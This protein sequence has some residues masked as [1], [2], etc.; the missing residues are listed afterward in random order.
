MSNLAY[1]SILAVIPIGLGIWYARQSE[2][3]QQTIRQMATPGD[4]TGRMLWNQVGRNLMGTKSPTYEEDV[5][6]YDM[7]RG[8]GKKVSKKRR[9]SKKRKWQRG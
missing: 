4:E 3:G 5:N 1:L 2:S 8:G 7:N 6:S 9:G